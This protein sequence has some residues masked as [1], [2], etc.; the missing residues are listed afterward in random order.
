M[1]FAECTFQVCTLEDRPE[2]APIW[3]AL[4]EGLLDTFH[5]QPLLE[6]SADWEWDTEKYPEYPTIQ[7]RNGYYRPSE[8]H[9]DIWPLIKQL[10]FESV[11]KAAGQTTMDPR[12]PRGHALEILEYLRTELGR[13]VPDPLY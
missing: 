8:R 9:A 5:Y 3:M 6:Q 11:R 7:S 4:D 13:G 2:H 1:D 10:H 12:T